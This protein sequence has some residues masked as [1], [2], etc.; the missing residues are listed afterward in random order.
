MDLIQA[1]LEN[2]YDLVNQAYMIYS[3]HGGHAIDRAEFLEFYRKRVN[4]W[5]LVAKEKE[6]RHKL[7]K[8]DET[9]KNKLREYFK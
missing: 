3:D 1:L 7:K 8:N 9:I 4:P 5:H 2:E 6:L